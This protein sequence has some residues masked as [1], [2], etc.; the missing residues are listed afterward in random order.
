MMLWRSFDPGFDPGSDGGFTGP[1]GPDFPV[2][3][4]LVAFSGFAGLFGVLFALVFVAAIAFGIYRMV[5]AHRA[6][7]QLGLGATGTFLAVTDEN[8]ATAFVASAAVKDAVDRQDAPRVVGDAPTG[9]PHAAATDVASRLRAL[10]AARDEGLVTDDE[11]ARA[12]EQI[13]AEA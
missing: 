4:G 9:A 10:A 7:Q 2:D 12:R 5:I 1:S 8:A 11:F 13:L 3:P 6:S